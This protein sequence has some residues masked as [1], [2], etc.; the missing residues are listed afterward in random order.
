MLAGLT[1]KIAVVTGGAG[2][3]GAAVC[4]RLAREGA[5]VVVADLDEAAAKHVADTVGGGAIGVAADVSTPDGATACVDV[6]V[7]AFGRL[8]LLHANAGVECV[9]Q[10]V[11]D[12]D[13][14]DY[15]KVFGVNVLGA[16]L[17]AQAAVRQLTA[18]G[19]GGQIL[20]T[21][22]IAALMG[23]GGTSV[24]NASKH[25][26]HGIARC[27]ALEVAGTG[28]R[29]NTLAPGAVESRMMDA[30]GAGLGAMAGADAAG[31]RTARTAA[32]PLGRYATP[33]EIAATAAWIL[34][35][36][37]PY[38]HNEV[39]TVGGGMAPY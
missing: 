23:T 12:F 11:A 38:L 34:S 36:E 17:S 2:V 6:A 32:L 1:G 16:F 19:G 30:L 18:Q 8:D 24:Y 7:A 3:I 25:A 14:G 9:V 29:V 33:E 39:V 31:F 35:D 21:A 5:K 28:I 20:F 13:P 37:V 27:L 4:D 26:V 15:H 22:S 10:P